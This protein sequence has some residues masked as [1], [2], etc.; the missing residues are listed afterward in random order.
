[1]KTRPLPPSIWML[2]IVGLL[3][4]AGAF[5]GVPSADGA[6]LSAGSHPLGDTP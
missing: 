1:M 3:V 6:R 5:L 2:P 4:L